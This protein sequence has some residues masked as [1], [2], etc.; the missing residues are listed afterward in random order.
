MLGR[1][2][3]AAA[4]VQLRVRSA[5]ATGRARTLTSAVRSLPP[6]SASACACACG[7]RPLASR[8]LST[9][10]STTMATSMSGM[11]SATARLNNGSNSNNKNN[12]P[13][14]GLFNAWQILA[15]ALAG[16]GT[17]AIMA[18]T[19]AAHTEG[20]D[21]ALPKPPDR[22]DLPTF[23][24]DEVARNNDPSTSF[25]VTWQ[26]GVYD[27]TEFIEQH[28]GGDKILLAAGANLEPFWS[29]YRQHLTPDVQNILEEY[30]I[31]SL[32]AAEAAAGASAFDENDPYKNDPTRHPAL[33]VHKRKPFNAEVPRTLITNSYITPASLYYVRHHHPVPVVDEDTWRLTIGGHGFAKEIQLSLKDLKTK[34]EPH[35]VVS[36]MQCG[37]NRREALDEAGLGTTQGLKWK[38]GAISTATWTGARLRD[39]LHAVGLDADTARQMGVKYINLYPLDPPY[40]ASVPVKKALDH[41]GDVILAYEMNG[42]PVPR[43]HGFP[44]RCIVPGYIGARSVKWMSRIEAATDESESMWQR[45]IPYKACSP[46]IKKFTEDMNVR[47]LPSVHDMPVQSAITIPGPAMLVE[48]DEEVVTVCGYAWSGSGRNIVRV[49]VSSDGGKTWTT[50]D[51][52][53]GAS[54]PEN[55]AW[56]W[57]FWEADVPVP[58]EAILNKRLELVCKAVDNS[59][60]QQPENP[61]SVWSLRGILNN[62]WHRVTLNV[63]KKSKTYID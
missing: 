62:S 50:A 19:S 43:D 28:P 27:V 13:T 6:T 17:L 26:Q 39:V 58:T 32:S 55:K 30:R 37:G 16:A 56:A 4:Q 5:L 45:G 22:P 12:N 41:D 35:T 24:R 23:S 29:L 3:A 51:L 20:D 33:L 42:E 59:F 25:W 38:T 57:T 36:T 46:N 54:Q 61:A 47:Q 49:D 53:D 8:A 15:G 34:F 1:V 2:A 40:D 60:N 7:V 48:P 44:V 18:T 14:S 10:T 11:L 31:G 63:E 9:T 21:D 52:L